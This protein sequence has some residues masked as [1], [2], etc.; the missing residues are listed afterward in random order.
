MMREQDVGI[1]V[2]ANPRLCSACKLLYTVLAYTPARTVGHLFDVLNRL[3]LQPALQSQTQF[4]HCSVPISRSTKSVE[5]IDSDRI[6][7]SIYLAPYLSSHYT[8]NVLT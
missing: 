6:Y 4:L 1:V 7:K 5:N 8:R 2:V 3:W